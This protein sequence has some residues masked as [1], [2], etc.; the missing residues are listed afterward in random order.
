MMRNQGLPTS[1]TEQLVG[2]A[3]DRT[4]R[5]YTQPTPA[6][7]QVVREASD[8]AFAPEGTNDR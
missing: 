5:G 7:V 2:H 6:Y 8:R 4:H 1:V 3:D